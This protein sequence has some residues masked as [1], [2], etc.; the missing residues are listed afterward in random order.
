M[1]NQ[2][3]P[4]LTILQ[5]DDWHLH[6][7]DGAI[8]RTVLPFT[9]K[10]FRRAIVMPNLTPPIITVP[11]C[12]NYRDRIINVVPEFEPLMTLYL[13]NTTSTQIIKEAAQ[14]DF[15][16]GV[17]L[18]PKGATTHS[19]DGIRKVEEIYKILEAME[20]HDLPLLVHGESIEPTLDVFDREKHFIEHSLIPMRKRFPALRIVLEHITT[21][22]AVHYVQDSDANT[23]ATI[24][25]HH[26]LYT[27]NALFDGGIRPHHYCLP[28]P[29][30][31]IHR[32]AVVEAACSGDAHFFLGTDSAPHMRR[33]KENS[34][35]CAGI[36][37]APVAL[38]VYAQ[39]FDENDKL[40]QL[41]Q[42][43]SINGP[44]FYKL[45]TNTKHI[46]LIKEQVSVAD[47]IGD[48]EIVPMLAGS[49]VTWRVCDE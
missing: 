19:D 48:E 15:I 32:A 5:P 26:L 9:A 12:R 39:I 41:E 25:P 30:R 42:F 20:H 21:R 29:Q 1:S 2:T 37:N 13:N 23:A 6:L 45:P 34:C 38:N 33:D 28:L 47:C 16:H 3:S 11:Q 49:T 8:M 31:E 27:R 46:S 7:R 14:C 35:G 40:D 44:H 43:A 24:T 4:K 36:F 22:E 18:Y 17:K 10:V